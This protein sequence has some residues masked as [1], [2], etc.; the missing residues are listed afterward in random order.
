MNKEKIFDA[1]LI[2]F[3]AVA[4]ILGAGLAVAGSAAASS[5]TGSYGPHGDCDEERHEAMEQAFEDGDY[6]TWAELMDGR[7][8]VTDVVTV[9]N[10]DTFVEL[11]EAQED[12]DQETARA[13]REELGLGMRAQDGSGPH[14]NGERMGKM[15]RGQGSGD[16]SNNRW[17]N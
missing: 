3:S 1:K 10:F 12:G 14:G 11:H 15:H 2:G 7:G 5:A 8:R 4:L 13:L 9:D 17:G 16:G 6:N